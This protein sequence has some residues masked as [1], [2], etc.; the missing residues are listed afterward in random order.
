MATVGLFQVAEYPRSFIN[1]GA[2]SGR[3]V[4]PLTEQLLIA[5]ASAKPVA[6][7]RVK[8]S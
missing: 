4:T 6:G 7:G 3:Y 8:L 5:S 2:F 1:A